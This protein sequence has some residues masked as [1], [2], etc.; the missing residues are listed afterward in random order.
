MTER[1][2]YVVVGG[3][4]AGCVVTNGL[5]SAG[6]SVSLLEAGPQDNSPFIHIPATFFRV[7][8]ERR[9]WMYLTAPER[10]PGTLGRQMILPQG[11]Y[12]R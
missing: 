5:V 6:K 9:T 12:R 3:G 4:S 2:D 8:G 11:P 10:E 1:Y 7:I